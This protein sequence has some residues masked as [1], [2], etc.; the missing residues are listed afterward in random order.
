MTPNK[1]QHIAIQQT[2]RAN[3]AHENGGKNPKPQYIV[4]LQNLY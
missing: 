2:D 1:S 3:T 4:F